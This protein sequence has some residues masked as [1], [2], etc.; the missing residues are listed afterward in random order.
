VEMHEKM[1]NKEKK[2]SAKKKKKSKTGKKNKEDLPNLN[3]V[4]VE[5]M[6]NLNHTVASGVEVNNASLDTKTLKP[7]SILK[8]TEDYFQDY[9]RFPVPSYQPCLLHEVM[10]QQ[11]EGDSS[12]V[13]AVGQQQVS[14]QQIEATGP[15]FGVQSLARNETDI[16][17]VGD[18]NEFFEKSKKK[19]AWKNFFKV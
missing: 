7:K 3:F 10:K 4:G 17:Q 5:E 11:L 16:A 6:G 8:K 19:S 12:G 14:C 13:Q 9:Q 18:F 2:K 15:S 1:I